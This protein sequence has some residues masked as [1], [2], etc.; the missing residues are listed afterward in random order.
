VLLWAWHHAIWRRRVPHLRPRRP[1]APSR[2]IL[3]RLPAPRMVLVLASGRPAAQSNAMR[4]ALILL[5]VRRAAL[6][7]PLCSRRRVWAPRSFTSRHPPLHASR[8]PRTCSSS[9]STNSNGAAGA[10]RAV[11][12][13][14][15][16]RDGLQRCTARC[17][18]REVVLPRSLLTIMGYLM[19]AGNVRHPRHR[20]AS[21]SLLLGPA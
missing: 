7:R 10:R 6:R 8:S 17:D 19:D 20:D 1:N 18:A 4:T 13:D 12:A 16:P 14:R 5:P 9:N 15:A 21:T 2:R 3:T 11:P